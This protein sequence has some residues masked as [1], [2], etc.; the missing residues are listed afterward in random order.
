MRSAPQRHPAAL[1]AA[2]LLAILALPAAPAAGQSVEIPPIP[3]DTFTLANG[4]HV[5][6]SPDH[7]TPLAAV[8]MWYN[9]GSAH[10]PPGRSGFAHLFE[11]M[12]FEE[13]ENLADGEMD[14]L[15]T[16]AG[17]IYNGTTNTDRT[18]YFEVVPSNR[19]NLALWLHAERMGRLVVS[20]ENFENQREVVKEERRLRVDNQPYAGAQATQD[21]LSQDYAPYRHTVIGSMEDLDAAR[22]E[23]VRDFHQRHYRPNNAVLAVVGDV[24]TDQIRAMAQEYFGGIARGPDPQPLPPFPPMPRVDG[25]RR[26]DVPDPQ[27][28]LPLVYLTFSA[29]PAA[30]P[31]HDALA[32]L[33]QI[34]STGESSRL[35]RRLVDEEQAALAV[36]ANVDRRLG[37]GSMVFGALPNQGVEVERLETLMLE[38]IGRLQEEGVSEREM[39][40]ARN[41]LRAQAVAA[42]ST[43]Q[44]KAQLLQ[45]FQLFHGSPFEAN[46]APARLEAVTA[47]DVRRVA[48]TYLVPTNRTVVVARPGGPAGA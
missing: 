38:E 2:P 10:E 12:L 39:E 25:E 44:S 28:Q 34:F 42:R 21:T 13:T 9:V 30:H 36:I 20:A 29:P 45:T 16:Q 41:Q 4:L 47:E 18:A 5:I 11:H 33:A 32:V 8:N 17:G 22:V 3:I 14:R 31:D 46:A 23:D 40:K 1:A 19:V 15:V 48:R 24:T 26:A 27:A 37:P 43:A 7:S 35:Q 6:V